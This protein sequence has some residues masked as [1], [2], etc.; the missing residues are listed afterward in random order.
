MPVSKSG[1]SLPFGG[2]RFVGFKMK[3]Q[4][5]NQE[6]HTHKK[7]VWEILCMRENGNTSI[8]SMTP[9]IASKTEKR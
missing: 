6:N 2:I 5:E 1:L 7:M 3:P 9:W 4:K 8:H